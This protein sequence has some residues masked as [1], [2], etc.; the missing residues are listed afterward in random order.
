MVNTRVGTHQKKGGTTQHLEELMVRREQY[1]QRP[2]RVGG[3][4]QSLLGLAIHK[5]IF[6][7]SIGFVF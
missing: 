4:Y 1:Y 2:T 7:G 6:F 3:L 5:R